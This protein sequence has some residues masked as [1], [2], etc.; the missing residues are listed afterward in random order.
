MVQTDQKQ[1]GTSGWDLGVQAAH[2]SLPN[3]CQGGN[4]SGHKGRDAPLTVCPRAL[5]TLRWAKLLRR[6]GTGRKGAL[7]TGPGQHSLARE[8]QP[9][10]CLPWCLPSETTCSGGGSSQDGG[11]STSQL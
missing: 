3:L 4:P 2:S 9:S 11:D 8:G 1:K 7:C 10:A 6:T 5:R